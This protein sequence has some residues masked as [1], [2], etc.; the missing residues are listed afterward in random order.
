MEKS[1]AAAKRIASALFLPLNDPRAGFQVVRLYAE[2]LRSQ[3]YNAPTLERLQ[4]NK[5]NHLLDQVRATVPFY[6]EYKVW[7]EVEEG[8][9]RDRLAT[10]PILTKE[11][12]RTCPTKMHPITGMPRACT[13]ATTGGTTGEPIEAWLGVNS[14]AIVEAASW[15]GKS[16]IG[17]EP[18]TRGVNVQGFGR[19]SW[20]GRLR[21]RLTNKWLMDVFGKTS[22][23]KRRS[24][25]KLLRLCPKY[26]EGFVSDSLALGEVCF[27][28]GVK[29]D[30]VLTTG[31]MLYEHQRRELER[32]YGAKVSD[33]YGC[34]E[35][36]AM[37][38]ECEMGRKHITDEHVIL[39][40]VDEAG[41]LV[42]DK[43]GRI[44]L[45]DLD[46]FLTPLVRYEVGDVG[47]LTRTPCS[48]GRKL[49][50]LKALEGRTQDAIRNEAGDKLS[51][52]FFAGR[53]RNLKTIHCIQIIQRSLTRIDLLY[54]GPSTGVEN[55]L[56]AIV[57]EI[58]GR[59][60]PQMV[61]TPRHVEQLVYTSRGKRRLIISLEENASVSHV[62]SIEDTEVS[63]V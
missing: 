19:G 30:R 60:G 28:A 53:F 12:I 2:L 41:A 15:R 34:N 42:W 31:E 40:V 33:Y 24:A 52:L 5:L 4:Q 26:L 57:G 62:G 43:P 7:Q 44:L 25:T 22:T 14:R 11:N 13:R 51:T 49:T 37:A 50:V 16:W 32:L 36:G 27:A 17:I 58:R 56:G 21:M 39:E 59:L 55:E 10:Y 61:V 3:W 47:V 35:I 38:F 63:E 8:A 29:I 18:W 54:E 45:T 20:Y 1:V 9:L 23:E 6:K 46:N 48:C